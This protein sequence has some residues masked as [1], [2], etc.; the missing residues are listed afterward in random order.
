M[1]DLNSRARAV[2]EAARDADDPSPADRDRIKHAVLVQVAAGLVASTA[3]AGTLTVGMSLGMKIGLVVLS[4]SLVIQISNGRPP[5]L[6]AL[7]I[8]S[9]VSWWSGLPDN[10]LHLPEE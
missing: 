7:A 9:S 10:M 4:V 3:A 1:N 5:A 2:I 8:A 6:A